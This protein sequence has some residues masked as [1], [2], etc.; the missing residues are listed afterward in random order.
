LASLTGG[1]KAMADEYT[2]SRISA[3]ACSA[4]RRQLRLNVSETAWSAVEAT[5]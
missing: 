2:R 1:W 4:L 5:E 3:S